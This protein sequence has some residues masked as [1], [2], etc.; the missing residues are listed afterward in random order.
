MRVSTFSTLS[1]KS[2]YAPDPIATRAPYL[3]E[4]T[5]TL[6]S[7]IS[8]ITGG[9]TLL[10]VGLCIKSKLC[11]RN[12]SSNAR[13]RSNDTPPP[14]TL[15]NFTAATM[16][17][18]NSTGTRH[19]EQNPPPQPQANNNQL[20]I[21]TIPSNLFPIGTVLFSL[22]NITTVMVPPNSVDLTPS[23]IDPTPSAVGTIPSAN[24]Q[25][26]TPTTTCA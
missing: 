2:T 17:I 19:S 13:T 21:L 20:S 10:L 12:S 22:D 26:T 15:S 9:L 11:K 8:L 3:D 18:H 1:K 24:G 6:I 5:I 25:P 14:T 4:K 16:D 23:V 7:I